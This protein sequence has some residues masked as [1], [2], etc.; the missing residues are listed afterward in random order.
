MTYNGL[1]VQ[2]LRGELQSTEKQLHIQNLQTKEQVSDKM[3]RT[4]QQVLC[5]LCILLRRYNIVSCSL[6]GQ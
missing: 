1:Q 4:V 5:I 3:D 2:Q 6:F